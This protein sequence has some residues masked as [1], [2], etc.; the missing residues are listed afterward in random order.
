MKKLVKIF[1][2]IILLIFSG[3]TGYAQNIQ[4]ADSVK[5]NQK[6]GESSASSAD[7]IKK[8]NPGNPN[9]DSQK[10]NGNTTVKL[11]KGARPDLSKSRGARPP[12]IERQPGAGIPKGIGK[13]GGAVKPGRR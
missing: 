1:F 4:K 8:D 6:K 3:H 9:T 11:L 5:L 10:S 13:P 12:Y 2:F 7:K